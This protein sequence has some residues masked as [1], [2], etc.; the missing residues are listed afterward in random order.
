MCHSGVALGARA[1]TRCLPLSLLTSS[2]ASISSSW[3]YHRIS[4]N[5]AKRKNTKVRTRSSATRICASA[6]PRCAASFSILRSAALSALLSSISSI[7]G[8]LSTCW[9][10]G[11][12]PRRLR[13]AG[14]EVEALATPIWEEDPGSELTTSGSSERGCIKVLFVANSG[15][16]GDVLSGVCSSWFVIVFF[17]AAL[18]SRARGSWE[19]RF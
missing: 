18:L 14:I 10:L 2:F 12:H 3:K 6:T 13:E 16:A 17:F 11:L 8:F 1:C 4:F 9:L 15:S 7:L 5:R 19:S